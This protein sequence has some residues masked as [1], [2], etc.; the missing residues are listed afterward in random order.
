MSDTTPTTK[1]KPRGGS[2]PARRL[3]AAIDRM[4]AAAR[5]AEQARRQ[6]AEQVEREGR[7]YA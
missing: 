7:R 6:L 1:R 4:L 2:P 3:L 5:D